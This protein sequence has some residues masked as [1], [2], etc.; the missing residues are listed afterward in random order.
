MIIASIYHT[1]V[2]KHDRQQPTLI[3]HIYAIDPCGV[4]FKSMRFS[5]VSYVHSLLRGRAVSFKLKPVMPVKVI[6]QRM[7]AAE[8]VASFEQ[9]QRGIT[10]VVETLQRSPL[11]WRT[12]FDQSDSIRVFGLFGI[13]S[14]SVAIRQAC[15][16]LIF[17]GW[18]KS[19]RTPFL[20]SAQ[21]D[22][23]VDDRDLPI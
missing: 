5:V 16:N 8:I 19:S 15:R 14:R 2:W 22:Q 12:T 21:R 4:V 11:E 3:R 13:N 7:L 9:V 6:L 17:P 18:T 1:I 20:E 10:K 23:V